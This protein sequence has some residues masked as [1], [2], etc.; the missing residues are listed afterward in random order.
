MGYIDT[1]MNRISFAIIFG[2]SLL[3]STLS[4]QATIGPL[5]VISLLSL[6][7]AIASL[8]LFVIACLRKD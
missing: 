6:V 2:F 5:K 1:D 7:L 8:I 4:M 3:A